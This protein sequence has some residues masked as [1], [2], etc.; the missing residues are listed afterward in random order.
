M[1]AT[2]M[3]PFPDCNEGFDLIIPVNS[4][5][6]FK[7]DMTLPGSSSSSIE[8]WNQ[9]NLSKSPAQDCPASP[10]QR[11]FPDNNDDNRKPIWMW[12]VKRD[13]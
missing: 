5:G 3:N 13:L 7:G 9:S 8:S 11:A 2:I 12:I 4:N 1:Y 6:F 10:C